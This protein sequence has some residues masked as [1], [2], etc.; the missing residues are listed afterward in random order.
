MDD[1]WQDPGAFLHIHSVLARR[2]RDGVRS[3]FGVE[4]ANEPTLVGVEL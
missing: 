4:L 2:I 3:A 1:P